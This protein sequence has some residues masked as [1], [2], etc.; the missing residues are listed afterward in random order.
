MLWTILLTCLLIAA[1]VSAW[2]WHSLVTVT[3]SQLV[4]ALR[5]RGIRAFEVTLPERIGHFAGEPELWLKKMVLDGTERTPTILVASPSKVANPH[6]LTYWE[7]KFACTIS[8]TLWRHLQKIF[9]ACKQLTFKNYEV[10]HAIDDTAGMYDIY[11]RW[12][13]RPPP[14]KLRAEDKDHG[15]EVL[16][17]WGLKEGDWFVCVHNRERGY[18]PSDDHY[19]EYRNSA[20]DTIIP[21]MREIVARGGWVIRMGDPSMTPLPPIEHVIDY[22]HSPLRSARLDIIL[23]ATARFFLGN[24]SGLFGVSTVFGVPVASANFTPIS[25]MQFTKHDL[26]IP[27]LL[28]IEQQNRLLTFPEAF[29]SPAANYRFSEQYQKDGLRVM[30]NSAEDIVDLTVEMLERVMGACTYTAHDEELQQA[31]RA[32]LKP[33]HYAY[34]SAARTGRDFLRKNEALFRAP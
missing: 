30:D 8:P 16:Q 28:Y 33:G 10:M 9:P 5:V 20:L 24:T 19:H 25:A 15:L 14:L 22:A 2:R 34:G 17:K 7:E 6:L 3:V 26:S 27:K 31:F 4:D 12:G 21:A 29:A 18:S 1:G 11:A 23:C 13:D 32:L